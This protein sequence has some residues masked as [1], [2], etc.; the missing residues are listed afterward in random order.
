MRL[1]NVLTR[2]LKEFSDTNRPP[3]VI[4]S[5]RWGADEATYR[6]VR[7]M[8]NTNKAGFRKI[9]RF[10]RWVRDN[11]SIKWIWIDTCCINK[12]S[13]TELSESINSMFRWYTESEFLSG[14]A[15]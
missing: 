2:E 11:C 3:C 6:D 12:D 13:A 9:R 10:C 14:M 4:V 5:H 15:P 8:R 1:L 7:S